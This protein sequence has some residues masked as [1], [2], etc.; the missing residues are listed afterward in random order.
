MKSRKLITTKIYSRTWRKFLASSNFNIEEGLPIN[1]ILEFLQR[2]LELNLST[3]GSPVPQN[4]RAHSTR[5]MATSWAERS[6]VSIDQI[7]RSKAQL[8]F[9]LHSTLSAYTWV[10]ISC[11]S[12]CGETKYAYLSSGINSSI[13]GSSSSLRPIRGPLLTEDMSPLSILHEYGLAAI[14]PPNGDGTEQDASERALP[15]RSTSPVIG[16][17]P[18]RA[19]PIGTPP[20]YVGPMFSQQQVLCPNPIHIRAASSFNNHPGSCLFGSKLDQIIKESTGGMSSLLPQA[21]PRHPLLKRKL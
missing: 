9:I 21:K 14:P 5:A 18:V 13:W 15:R 10:S 12:D 6:G 1:Q 11:N 8:T 3:S 20:K 4:L 17:P 2:G 19:V 7:Y 16:S